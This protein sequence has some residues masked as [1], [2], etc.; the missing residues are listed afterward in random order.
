M[1]NCCKDIYFFVYIKKNI[2]ICTIKTNYNSK[3]NKFMKKSLIASL[4]ALALMSCGNSTG[5]GNT[6]A[7][8]S[9]TTDSISTADFDPTPSAEEE[10]M[11]HF[12]ECLIFESEETPWTNYDFVKS[13]TSAECQ[14]FLHENYPYDDPDGQGLAIWLLTGRTENDSEMSTREILGNSIDLHN[15]KRMVKVHLDIS[16]ESSEVTR[17]IYYDCSYQDDEVIINSI[18]YLD[19][20]PVDPNADHVN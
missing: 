10:K 13:H 20:E 15:G 7:T 9:L 4:F 3:N 11:M 6:D 19:D 17:T 5:N 16:D 12:V 1:I 2:Y 14:Q 8:D 18:E